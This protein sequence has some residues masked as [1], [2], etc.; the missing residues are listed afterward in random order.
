MTEPESTEEVAVEATEEPAD[1]DAEE[2]EA[3][4]GD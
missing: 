3:V 1:D 2:T 4:E